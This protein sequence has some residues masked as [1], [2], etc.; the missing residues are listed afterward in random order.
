MQVP[1][2]RAMRNAHALIAQ[3]CFRE[4]DDKGMS[5]DLPVLPTCYKNSPLVQA[6]RYGT[7]RY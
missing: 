4:I 2:L 6:I 1:L 3:T 7:P 5:I